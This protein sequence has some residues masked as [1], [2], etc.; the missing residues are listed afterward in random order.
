MASLRPFAVA[1]LFAMLAASPAWAQQSIEGRILRASDGSPVEDVSVR[2][3]GEDLLVGT[4][5]AGFF[6]FDL[7]EDRPGFGLEI[8]VIG[9]STIKRTWMLPLERPLVIAL[10]QDVVPLEG[11]DVEV[12]RP[13][14]WTAL[15]MEYKLEFRAKQIMGNN[16]SANLADLRDFKHQEAEIWDFLP[17]M[18]AVGLFDGG[19]RSGGLVRS[20]MY[21]MDERVV[22]FD[23]FRSYAVGE[24]CRLDLITI[25]RLAR[26]RLQGSSMDHG[27]LVLGYTCDYLMDVAMGRKVL[28]PFLPDEIEAQRQQWGM[29][30]G[31]GAPLP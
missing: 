8:E 21:V 29:G 25:P 22:N 17:Q 31:G 27:G 1:G 30:R 14:G 26:G 19:F 13:T 7:P 23:E 3:V 12:D 24:M 28:T 10:E 6:R 11:I 18:N 20:P 16:R 5:S 9:F 4:D 15:P 2:V